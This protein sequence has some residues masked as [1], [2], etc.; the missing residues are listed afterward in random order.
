[1]LAGRRAFQGEDI[2][3][4]LAA[5]LRGEPDWNALPP[6]VPSHVRTVIQRC[7]TKDRRLRVSDISIVAYVFSESLPQSPQVN[8]ADARVPAAGGVPLWQRILI[9]A[10]AALL[11]AAAVA[12]ALWPSPS[13]TPPRVARFPM[14][15]AGAQTLQVDTQSHDLAITPNGS[16]VVYKGGTNSISPTQLFVRPISDLDP[17]PLSTTLGSPKAPFSSPDG[18]WIGYFEPGP[19]TLKKV[20]LTGGP[21]LILCQVDGASRGATW[22]LDDS[23]IFATAAPETGLQRV[24]AGGGQPTTLTT[25]NRALGENDH[26]WPRSL[27]GGQAVLF[28]ITRANSDIDS[29]QIAV[30]DVRNGSYKVVLRGGT[31]AV[32]TSTGH[33]VYVAAGALRAIPFDLERLET[34]GHASQVLPRVVTLP[35]GVAEFDLATDGTLIYVAEGGATTPSQ[36]TLVWVDRKGQEQPVPNI[37]TRAYTG[38]QLSPEGSR[39]AVEIADQAYD[40]W[41]WSFPQSTLTRITTDPGFDEAPVWTPDGSHLIFRSQLGGVAGLLY[42]QRADGS[43]SP[44]RLTDGPHLQY[45]SQVL[46]NG[47]D[48]VLWQAGAAR[49]S[50]SSGGSTDVMLFTMGADKARPLF[51]TPATERGAVVSPDGRWLAYQSFESRQSEVFV[52]P[53]PNVAASRIQVSTNGGA[54]PLWTRNGELLYRRMDGALMSVLVQPRDTWSAGVP[55]VLLSRTPYYF[56]AGA[57][58]TFDVSADGSRF[59]MIKAADGANPATS[60]PTIVIVQNWTEEL[61][62]LVPTTR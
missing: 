47:K 33:L 13:P 42:R 17:A 21:P 25:P 45:P 23:I 30:Y 12:T 36:R 38:V 56:R 44:E 43:G 22:R 32:Y 53:F 24:S 16:H 62:R 5:V 35:T 50:N 2:A 10:A 11:S 59:L 58:K 29:S 7:L 52:R 1:M 51:E 8:P 34:R 39:V 61:K 31:Q 54:E 48:I 19:V 37:H 28:T 40:V 49:G 27:P 46:P 60:A 18:Q 3:D 9:P 26:L 41:V 15:P 4:T 20:A 14:T 57:S 55:T 6:D